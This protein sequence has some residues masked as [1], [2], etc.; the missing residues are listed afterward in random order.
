MLF[1]SVS[2]SRY[3]KKIY[4]T[5]CEKRDDG[6]GCNESNSLKCV[7][8]K[9]NHLQELFIDGWYVGNRELF[10]DGRYVSNRY[11]ELDDN[12]Y[13]ATLRRGIRVPVNKEIYDAWKKG[14]TNEANGFDD[15]IITFVD[16]NVMYVLEF[17]S[18]II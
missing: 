18:E 15:K 14:F 3:V 12:S 13:I 8:C 6:K 9:E 16:G 1:R 5:E 7:N 17:R 11:N 4:V 2:Q 10:I